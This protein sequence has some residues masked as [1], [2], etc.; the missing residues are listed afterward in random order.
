VA[1]TELRGA[2]DPVEINLHS[3]TWRLSCSARSKSPYQCA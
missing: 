3:T 1:L 2:D